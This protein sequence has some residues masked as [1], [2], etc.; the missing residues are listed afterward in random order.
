VKVHYKDEQSSERLASRRTTDSRNYPDNM[1]SRKKDQD[2]KMYMFLALHLLFFYPHP[3][4][5]HTLTN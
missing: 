5:V 1:D 4:C 3:N 2:I